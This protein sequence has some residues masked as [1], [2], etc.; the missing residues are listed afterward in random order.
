MSE[1]V[2]P[3]LVICGPTAAGKTGLALELRRHL[4]IEVISADSRQVYRWMDIGTAKAT[5]AELALLPHHLIDVVDPDQTFS[6]ADFIRLGRDAVSRIVRRG[7][8]PVLVGGTG[9]YVDALLY[10]LVA[11]PPA[12]PAL[13][14]RLMEEE[15]AQGEG[16]LHRRLM[17]VDRA[18]A[19]RLPPR[20][21]VR[22]VRALEVFILGGKP[23]SLLQ[24]EQA[25]GESPYRPVFLG[26]DVERNEL[27]RRIDARAAAMFA[28]GLLEETRNLVQRGYSSEL[29]AMGTIG[30][31]EACRHLAG[32][33]DLPTAVE[34][35]R[36][37]TRRYAK[38]QFTWFR[39]NK[40]IIWLDSG[41]EFD[42]ILNIAQRLHDE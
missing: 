19:E 22:I 34:C 30:Y 41:K 7:Q 38:R 36:Q 1:S 24:Q 9:L 40:S 25:A 35:T 10:G 31:R 39:K 20:D 14:E 42:K 4:P 15:A 32:E 33:I 26:V 2:I 3:L 23:L 18:L 17:E 6:V 11:A 16:T 13:R 12:D 37:E 28:G 21:L 27:Y 5:A 8:L 29:K